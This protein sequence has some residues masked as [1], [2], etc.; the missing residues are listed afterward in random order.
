M[1][2]G[3]RGRSAG[4]SA[5]PRRPSRPAGRPPRLVVLAGLPGVGKSTLARELAR[6]LGATWLRVD[7]IEAALLKAGLPRSFETGLAAY[8]A[9]ADLAVE[10]LGVGSDVVIDAVNGVAEARRLWRR[11]AQRTGA[12]RYVVELR[13]DDRAE[14]RHRVEARARP[15]PPLPS[16][17]WSE[18]LAREY[19]PWREPILSVDG[20]RPVGETVPRVLRH[21][22]GPRR[23]RR[24]AR[25]PSGPSGSS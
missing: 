9:A 23:G 15:T 14:H 12:R 24:A 11:V 10:A 19:V 25:R 6:A 2:K 18:V 22:G 13:C 3:P 5:R 21:L 4:A 16:P 8:V 1:A 17:S 20:R 7:T